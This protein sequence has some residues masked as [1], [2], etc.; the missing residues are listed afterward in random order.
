MYTR[1][2][3]WAPSPVPDPLFREVPKA[4]EPTRS[5]EIV[6]GLRHRGRPLHGRRV[7]RD[8]AAVLPLVHRARLPVTGHQH[9]VPTPTGARSPTGPGCCWRSSTRS[10]RRSVRDTCPRGPPLRRRAHRGRAPRSTTR[11]R[12]PGWSTPAGKVDYINTSIGVAT[13]TLFMIEASMQVPPGYA[14][15]IPSAIR[16]AVG[17]PVVGVGP[18]QRPPP[19]RPGPRRRASAIWS[20]WCAARSPTPISRPRRAR[21]TPPRSAAACPAT[22]SAWAGWASTGGWAASRTRAPGVSRWR[23]QPPVAGQ[24]WWWSAAGPAGSRRR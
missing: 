20:A 24:G 8:R 23:S 3:V 4:V 11:W 15:F 16:E 5:R 19:G 18:V 10:E 1:L 14:M 13:A 6:D 22:R 12:W 21:G 2:P 7:R 17:V 9:R